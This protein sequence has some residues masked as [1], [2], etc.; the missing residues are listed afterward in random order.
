MAVR[1]GRK[2]KRDISLLHKK[3][4]KGD[5]SALCSKQVSRKREGEEGLFRF[6][7]KEKSLLLI[8]PYAGT[9]KRERRR[10]SNR[11]SL[12]G[13]DRGGNGGGES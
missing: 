11:E 2:G 5:G 6:I 9:E 10:A 3:G 4:R 7:M 8:W 13:Q 12:G 1:K